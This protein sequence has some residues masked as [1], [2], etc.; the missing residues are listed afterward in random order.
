M[1]LSPEKEREIRRIAFDPRRM[2]LIAGRDK[3]DDVPTVAV[4]DGIFELLAEIDSLR[5]II[6]KGAYQNETHS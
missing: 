1:T 6:K 2:I 3:Y 4:F 5:A